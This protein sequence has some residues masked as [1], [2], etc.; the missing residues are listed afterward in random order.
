MST[1]V[2]TRRTFLWAAIAIVGVIAAL[3]ALGS[4][5]DRRGESPTVRGAQTV[6]VSPDGSTEPAAA[7]IEQPMSIQEGGGE[8][9]A[10]SSA[11]VSAASDT[12]DAALSV[13]AELGVK[14]IQNATLQLRVKRG[15][16]DDQVAEVQLI[17]SAAGGYVVSSSLSRI[18]SG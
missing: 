18:G 1:F 10:R 5:A 12:Q 14:I 6:K 16:L 3:V 17:A 13:P 4:T 7:T 9:A 2:P 11:P 15:S 8:S